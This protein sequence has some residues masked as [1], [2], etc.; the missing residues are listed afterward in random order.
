MLF[1]IARLAVEEDIMSILYSFENVRT[2][3][4]DKFFEYVTMLGE[5]VALLLV[6]MLFYWCIN[7]RQGF[8]MLY[9][10]LLGG[11][12][13]S[14]LKLIFRIPRPWIKDS[15]FTIVEAARE[16]A[17]GYSFPSGHTQ[18]AASYM[19]AIFMF[20]KNKAAKIL[21]VLLML[22]VGLSRMYLGV[23]TPMDVG[24]ALILGF[25]L[26]FIFYPF[27][28]K[29]EDKIH[30]AFA[31]LIAALTAAVLY[32]EFYKF[33][34]DVDAYNLMSGK[35]NAYLT[36]GAGLGMVI[37]YYV[38]KKYI[39]F[40][41]KALWWV[42]ILKLIGGISLVMLFRSIVKQP[43]LTL[44]NGSEIA[45]GVRYLGMMLIA[46]IVWPLTFKWFNKL[47][48]SKK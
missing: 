25:I 39:Q 34:A 41:T 17:T 6:V 7:K 47:G 29:R 32:V 42:Q 38:D 45:T 10:G 4:F 46:G 28:S 2:D 48:Q 5:E 33:P 26:M 30:W 36:L 18:N 24:V 22:L 21:S 27:F 35:Q 19:G 12:I 3:F 14:F 13:S 8:F 40:E 16:N 43:L 11:G 15:N 1:N 44:F 9:L 31:F 37:S 20:T 23:H